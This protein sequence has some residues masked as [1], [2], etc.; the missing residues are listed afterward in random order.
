M[1]PNEI[2]HYRILGRLGGGGMGVVYEGEDIRLGRKVALKFLPQETENDPQALER[3]QR[4]ARAA[5][6]L[7][8]PHICTIYEIDQ[9]EGKHF[10]V[11]ELLEGSTLN[12]LI[13]G[14]PLSVARLLDIAIDIADALDAA[15]SKG[16]VHRDIK[17]GN[18]F[19]TRRGEAKV[20]DFGLAKVG[21]LD[22][23]TVGVSAPPTATLPEHLTSP[24]VA[25]G[26]VAYM[27]PEQARG[28]LLDARTDLFS[29]GAVLYEMATGT[30]PF[31]GNTSAVVFDSVLNRAPT[32]PIRVNPDLPPELERIINKALEKDR[33]LRFQ[34]AAELRADLKRMKR[35]SESGR[36]SSAQS[37]LPSPKPKRRWMYVVAAL[38][39]L[40]VIG[41]AVYFFLQP[42]WF[43]PAA[44]SSAD[45]I[46]LTD[47]PDS[48]TQPALSPD[49]HLLVFIRGPE[50]FIT[51]GQVYL[52]FLPDGQPIQ[53]TH[54]DRPKI[55]PVFSP[56][57]SRIAYTG[58]E[59]FNWNTYQIPVTGGESKL[60]LPNASG[61]TWVDGQ[62]LLFSEIK[63]G[64]H[65]GLVTASES[66][67]DE[68]EVYL[69]AEELGMAHRSYVSPDR[70]SV[71]AVEMRSPEWLR[72]R[73]LPL[74]GSSAGTPI[75]PDGHCT[76]AA[77]SPDGKWIY[78]TSDAGSVVS[79]SGECDTQ[80]GLPSVLLPDR[81]KR[82]ELLWRRMVGR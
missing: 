17:P 23:A 21:L 69:P 76:S 64:A 63:T 45:W 39:M 3:F 22:G 49:G 5:S 32:A 71:V 61:L 7:N 75:G 37:P 33:D 51:D 28:E 10:I 46:Q 25:L 74:D 72:C 11:M 42:S 58:L 18:I 30:V 65:M 66:R 57:G 60:L 50:T 13:S 80:T 73:L 15:H 67:G 2:S 20:L 38:L 8:H 6:A 77:W 47:F 34:T 26:T 81:R 12:Y 27:S 44:I 43:Q 56:D 19:V 24:G 40:A 16:I 55:S 41:A 62:R 14:R 9:F 78:L 82:T 1:V 29:F 48:A 52:K 4:E 59:N 68:R 79:T 36:I 53:L 31:K 70:K 54:D 35:D